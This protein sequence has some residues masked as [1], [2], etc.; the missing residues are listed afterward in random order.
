MEPAPLEFK[1]ASKDFRDGPRG[2]VRAVN[3]VS[4]ALPRGAVAL[5]HGPSGAGKSTLLALGAG[6][7]LPSEGEVWLQG[8][9]FSRLREAHRAS[10]RRALLGVLWQ[11]PG[12][13]PGLASLAQVLLPSVPEGLTPARREAALRWLA[14]FGLESAREALPEDLSGGEKQRVALARAFARDPSLL[15]LDEPSAHLDDP[16]VLALGRA[17]GALCAR[18]GSALVVTHDPR[19]DALPSVSERRILVQGSLEAV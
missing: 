16:S 10:R 9:H 8:A 11:G 14:H 1:R 2:L 3:S 19:L 18:G 5:L 7:L 12:L 4:W 13:I 17:L 15:L 6:L